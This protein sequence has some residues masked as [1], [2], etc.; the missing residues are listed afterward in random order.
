MT[1]P[2]PACR[3]SADHA[4]RTYDYNQR[5][6]QDEFNYYRCQR[7]GLIFLDPIPENLGQYYSQT[8]YAIPRSQRDLAREAASKRYQ[9]EIVRRY[10]KG[11]RLLDIGPGHGAFA[12]LAKEAGFDVSTIEMDPTCCKFLRDE[13][14][15]SAIQSDN[16]A[17]VLPQLEPQNVI[18]LWHVIEHLPDPWTTLARAAERLTPGGILLIAAPNPQ[19]LQFS[20]FRSRW[21]H[22]DAPRHVKL[23]PAQLLVSRLVSEG[24]QPVLVTTGDPGGRVLNQ[25][26]WRASLINL[27]ERR[28]PRAAGWRLGRPLGLLASP[29]ERNG[30]RGSAYTAI[31]RKPE[32]SAVRQA[33]PFR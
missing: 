25:Y 11:G 15:V 7:C 2:C 10:V 16:P 29:F 8:Y 6:S 20:L 19:A 24:L 27:S 32:D 4:Y 9:I 5:L 18:T 26:G 3:G 17:E 33:E 30:L 23:L 1:P 14:G 21:V 28:L 22:L 13:V 31:F 12:F